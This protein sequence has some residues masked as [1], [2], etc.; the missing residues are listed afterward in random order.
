MSSPF[1]D[2]WVLL[3][4]IRGGPTGRRMP[5]TEDESYGDVSHTEHPLHGLEDDDEGMDRYEEQSMPPMNPQGPPHDMGRTGSSGLPPVGADD[6][7]PDDI[8]MLNEFGDGGEVADYAQ[9]VDERGP[10]NIFPQPL[11]ENMRPELEAWA[12]GAGREAG[13]Q[14]PQREGEENPHQDDPEGSIPLDSNPESHSIMGDSA[15]RSSPRNQK[16]GEMDSGEAFSR[17]GFRGPP[18]PLT[19]ASASGEPAHIQQLREAQRDRSRNP[20]P[21]MA[22]FKYLNPNRK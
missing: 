9:K 1:Q 18:M 4:N 13:M 16:R 15:L 12:D 8:D 17:P 19:D 11:G 20:D 10:R 2:A 3:K 6:L 21:T 5:M 14:G 22:R 7:H